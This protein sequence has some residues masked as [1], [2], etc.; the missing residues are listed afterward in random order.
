M[1]TTLQQHYDQLTKLLNE[2]VDPNTPLNLTVRCF[3]DGMY[4]EMCFYTED[5]TI[6]QDH[7]QLSLIGEDTTF[8]P[9]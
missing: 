1:A 7:N 3:A 4:D 8:V 6:S 9:E 2:G 5:F